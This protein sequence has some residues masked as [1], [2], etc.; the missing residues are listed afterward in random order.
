MVGGD[1]SAIQ[2]N[3]AK[4]GVKRFLPKPGKSTLPFQRAGVMDV[5]VT[6]SREKEENL[7]EDVH[8]RYRQ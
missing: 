5:I 7:H 8:N 3:S 2:A 6:V 1:P 4:Y